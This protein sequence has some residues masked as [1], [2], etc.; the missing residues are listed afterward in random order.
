MLYWVFLTKNASFGCFWP[1]TCKQYCHIWN[2][3]LQQKCLNLGPR[4]ALF[5]YFLAGIWKQYC[6]IWNQGIQQK[7]INL[8]LKMPDLDIFGQELK[9]TLLPY[10][11]S[12][13]STKIHKFGTKNAW[14]GF[15][16]ARIKKHPI[17]IFEISTLRFVYLHNFTKNR[18]CLN[19]RPKMPSLG[20]LGLEFEYNI[21]I[22]EITF[23][24]FL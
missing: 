2:Q 16:W 14:F 10:L 4:K 6:H 20:I 19:L 23:L 1:G 11:K 5:G 18:K 12:G 17:A 21:V 22:F 15:F 3:H 24:K 9:K 7:F 8:G 13:N